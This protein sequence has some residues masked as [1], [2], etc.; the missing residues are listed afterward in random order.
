MSAQTA[1]V[2]RA[3]HINSRAE[4]DF[5]IQS[6]FDKFMDCIGLDGRDTGG[7]IKFA[8]ADPI[9]QS[10]HRIGASISI[11]IMGAAAGA[12]IVWRM[13]T[14]KGQ[15]LSLDL[16]KA[17]HGVNP[18]Y[19]FKPTVNGYPYQM[20]YGLGNPLIFDLYLT[21]DGRWALPTGGYPHMLTEWCSLLGCSP[22]KT[23]MANAILKWDSHDLDE[24]AADRNMVFA[25]CRSRE[26]WARHSQG[27]LLAA[28]PLIE[29]EKVADSEPMPFG[30]AE[31]PLAG[32]R[33]LSATHVIAGNVVSRTLAEQGAK[34][35]HID[36]PQ[37]F[38]HE[39]FT[40]D[41]TVG[42]MSAW[43]DLKSL[44]GNRRGHQLARDADVF[45]ESYRGRSLSRLGFSP[46]ELAARRPGTV[47]CSVRCYGYDGPWANR[48]GFDM[49]ALCVSGF[50]LEEGTP[51][52]PKFPPTHVM[53]DFIA[54][55][56]GAAGVTAA[57]IR[58]AQQG[59]SYHV[60]ICLTRNAMWYSTLGLIDRD[61]LDGSNE[62]HRLLPPDAIT[63][64]TPYGEV[65]RLAPHV[66]FSE[67]PGYWE[68]PILTVRGS[69]KPEWP[70]QSEATRSAG[71][72]ARGGAKVTSTIGNEHP[73]HIV[74]TPKL[75]RR[76]ALHSSG[77]RGAA[78]TR[79]SVRRRSS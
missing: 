6:F 38:E 58:R 52:R 3:K 55:Y 66:K 64:Q 60:K 44:E 24:A 32:I 57:L 50:T 21:K 19:M 5:D 34:V 7:T 18:V 41:C 76:T 53:N 45:V 54:G 12:A 33:V 30:P 62:Q 27:E 59:G 16:R 46:E 20:P 43:L 25:L 68:D 31:R 35:L 69:C 22:E 63:R 23:S 61:N 14:G 15:D 56:M 10:R 42:Q 72:T 2:G 29:I 70:S 74:R 13:R 28:K 79:K 8:G 1:H 39:I 73:R 11:P 40:T 36:R 17:I 71:T 65:Y 4:A 77:R 9:Y 26:E 67:T 49:E 47:Y 37:E 48:G 75:A 78:L 51:D